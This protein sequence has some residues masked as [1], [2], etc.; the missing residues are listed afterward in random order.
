MIAFMVFSM[1]VPTFW[2]VGCYI[3][4]GDI[5]YGPNGAYRWNVVLSGVNDSISF[6]QYIRRIFFF[7]VSWFFL[8]TPVVAL[9]TVFYT[10]KNWKNPAISRCTWLWLIPFVVLYFT[11]IYKSVE[12]TLLLQHR[13]TLSLIL[14]SLPFYALMF[15]DG[16]FLKAKRIIALAVIVLFIPYSFLNRDINSI[17]RL[18]NQGTVDLVEL[19]NSKTIDPANE[20]LIIDF[21][22]WEDTYYLSLKSDILPENIF[23]VNGAI[24]GQVYLKYLKKV[25]ANHSE[26][27]LLKKN[28]KS[29]LDEHFELPND[30]LIVIKKID[31]QL[32]LK[33]V[34]YTDEKI[35][36]YRYQFENTKN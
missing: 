19:I 3:D 25:L 26:G 7:T 12:G 17:P 22:G 5:F 4:T 27:F 2:M 9:L 33:E 20:S 14:T 29:K 35:K 36:V 11:F 32:H 21:I 31:V 15:Q 8:L 28:K 13:F 1:I 18:P 30:S 24:H 16:K 10:I 23:R 34:I 6:E